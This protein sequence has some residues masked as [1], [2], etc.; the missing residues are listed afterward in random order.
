MI[1]GIEAPLFILITAFVILPVGLFVAAIVLGIRDIIKKRFSRST[2][3]VI[4]AFILTVIIR[5]IIS[6]S[7]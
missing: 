1:D 2:K 6:E 4:A 3:I 7:Y 5:I